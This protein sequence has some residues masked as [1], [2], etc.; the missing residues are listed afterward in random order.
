MKGINHMDELFETDKEVSALYEKLT[1]AYQRMME[2]MALSA[3]IG[4]YSIVEFETSLACLKEFQGLW[5]EFAGHFT[6]DTRIEPINKLMLS[7]LEALERLIITISE[8]FKTLIGLLTSI[9]EIP[10][11][12]ES[13][14]S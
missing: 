11:N 9:V 4:K 10:I 13:R 6:S 7:N 12:I 8:G 5:V 14:K 1:S 2:H 3:R